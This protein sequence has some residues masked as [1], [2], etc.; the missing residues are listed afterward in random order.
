MYVQI[1]MRVVFCRKEV[2]MT[3][4]F[5]YRRSINLGGGFRINL[6]KS[7]IGYSWGTQGYRITKTAKG[8]IRQTFSI[9]GSGMSF[10]DEIGKGGPHRKNAQ[11]NL[12]PINGNIYNTEQIVNGNASNMISSD[13]KDILSTAKKHYF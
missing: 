9:P 10:V 13:L 12:R 7:G 2:D 8:S 3:M 5:R 1:I 6:S 4:G 11:E